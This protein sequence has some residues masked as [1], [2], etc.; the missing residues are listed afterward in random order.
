MIFKNQTEYMNHH[1]HPDGSEK[2]DLTPV[3]MPIDG[4]ESV[5]STDAKLKMMMEHMIA[6]KMAAQEFESK[7][8]DLDFD[9]PSDL[10]DNKFSKFPTKEEVYEQIR[11]KKEQNTK[12]TSDNVTRKAAQTA[13]A[14]HVEPDEDSGP[15]KKHNK[16]TKSA[17]ASSVEDADEE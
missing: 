7:L 1:F 17:N 5:S 4:F 11:K 8:D 14:K 15:T 13:R 2:L 10:P 6:N 9:I 16:K 12:W 3:E